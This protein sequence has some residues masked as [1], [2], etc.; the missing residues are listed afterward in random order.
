MTLYVSNAHQEWG[1]YGLQI[2]VVAELLRNGLH[3]MFVR[4]CGR[5][6][7]ASVAAAVLAVVCDVMVA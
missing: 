1:V 4:V 6:G 3:T 2:G 5:C 7:R